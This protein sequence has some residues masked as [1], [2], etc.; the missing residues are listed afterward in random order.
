MKNLLMDTVHT[1][2]W[3][4]NVNEST[5]WRSLKIL[6]DERTNKTLVQTILREKILF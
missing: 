6:R 1:R 4:K 2:A 5:V 3:N